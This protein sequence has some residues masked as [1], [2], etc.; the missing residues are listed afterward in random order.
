[1]RPSTPSFCGKVRSAIEPPSNHDAYGTLFD[2][3]SVIR[4]SGAGIPG[5]FDALSQ[6]WRQKQLEYTSLRALMDRYEDFWH[7]TQDALRSVVQQPSSKPK[8]PSISVCSGDVCLD[9]L[10]W[11]RPDISS[12]PSI[13]GLLID[14]SSTATLRTVSLEFSLISGRVLAGA[15]AAFFSSEIPPGARWYFTAYFSEYTLCVSRELWFAKGF[16]TPDRR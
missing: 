14:Y 10:R 15:T 8:P 13:S 4:N 12:L 9:H 5:N 2:V 16:R 1:V 11:V 6:L 7:I 3:H